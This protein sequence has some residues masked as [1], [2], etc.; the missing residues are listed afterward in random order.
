[1]DP[2]LEE[3][4]GDFHTTLCVYARNQL[5]RVLPPDLIARVEERLV[6]ADPEDM[7]GWIRPDAHIR[8]QGAPRVGRMAKASNLAAVAE[9]IV[10]E[11]DVE[12]ET[13]RLIEIRKADA[14]GAV[15]TAIEL[16]S[17]TNKRPGSKA[18]KD[19]QIKQESCLSAGIHLVEIDLIRGGDWAVSLPRGLVRKEHMTP[20][21]VVVRRAWPG[22]RAEFYP[23]TLRQRLPTIRVPLRD[24][25]ED[26]PLELQ[27]LMDQCYEDGRYDRI[28]YQNELVNPLSNG[29]AKWADQLLRGAGLRGK[30]KRR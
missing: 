8:E 16:L 11:I 28:D 22:F 19:Y 24:T 12:P 10:I 3:H 21:R 25:D 2:Y 1:M 30:R 17:P 6:V 7:V 5:Q 20:Y 4:W 15:I 23:I 9:P 26:A 29:D 18:R 14:S 27:P 13:Q